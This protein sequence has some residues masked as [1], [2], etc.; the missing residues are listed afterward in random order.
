MSN[1]CT[2]HED[3]I[4]SGKATMTRVS[5][6]IPTD[7]HKQLKTIAALRSKTL[8]QLILDS[9]D[10]CISKQASDEKIPEHERWIYDPANRKIV[11]H[12]EKGLKQKASIYRGSFAKHAKK[13]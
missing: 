9:L 11:E 7:Y 10:E 8:R 12:I 6:D 4:M 5:L 3:S 13:Q 2:K 1:S